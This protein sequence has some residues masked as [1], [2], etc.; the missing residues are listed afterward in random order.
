M[1]A[2]ASHIDP[3]SSDRADSKMDNPEGEAQARLAFSPLPRL[4]TGMKR[5]VF[6]LGAA[7]GLLALGVPA[8]QA[9]THPA[10]VPSSAA[11]R[12]AMGTASAQQLIVGQLNPN[13]ARSYPLAAPYSGCTFY[14]GDSYEGSGGGAVGMATISCPSL[15]T[16][17][18][19][20]YLDY[21]D[22][23]NGQEYT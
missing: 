16:Y 7:A 2:R 20:V 12:T 1:N 19:R 13:T 4:R 18:I 10:V 5:L 9:S 23:T 17:R 21:H 8:A 22:Y 6:A 14:V 15:H 3:I 11:A